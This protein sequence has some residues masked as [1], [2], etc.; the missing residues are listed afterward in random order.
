MGMIE[1]RR[2]VT[3]SGRDVVGEWLAGLGDARTRAK[4][5][6]R[7]AR[8]QAGNLGDCKP[9]GEGV[10]ELR[11]D[12][13]PGYRVYYARAGRSVVLLLYGGDKRMQTAD[14]ATALEHWKDY[15]R[16]IGMK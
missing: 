3:A 4:I 1:I 8:V 7:L 14:I 13:G 5:A 6:A 10:W 11:V 9:V 15:K 12:W 16:R 2:Y